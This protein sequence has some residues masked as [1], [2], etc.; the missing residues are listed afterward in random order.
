MCFWGNRLTD[1]M[2]RCRSRAALHDSSATTPPYSKV[3]H[4]SLFFFFFSTQPPLP[5]TFCSL[6][7]CLFC[8]Y[9]LN[10]GQNDGR[11]GGP[12][13]WE[14]R[15]CAAGWGDHGSVYGES[16]IEVCV[17]SSEEEEA[18]DVKKGKVCIVPLVIFFSPVWWVLRSCLSV[19]TVARAFAWCLFFFFFLMDGQYS[20]IPDSHNY[21]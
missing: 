7:V 18:I 21:E 11:D 16:Q 2:T 4:T 9:L 8:S 13:I 20:L 5:V 17:G 6:Y 1:R 15:L 14:V 3:S 12:R 10:P 19:Q